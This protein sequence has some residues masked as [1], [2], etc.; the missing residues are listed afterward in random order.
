MHKLKQHFLNLSIGGK[1]LALLSIIA[2]VSTIGI[3]IIQWQVAS[4]RGA[5]D[6]QRALLQRL[7]SV[8]LAVS[9]F[10]NAKYWYADLANSLS[11]QAED[12]AAS[13]LKTFRTTIEAIEGLADTDRQTLLNNAAKIGEL[14]LAALDEYVIEERAA[15]NALMDEARTLVAENDVILTALL[16]D[17]RNRASAAADA[18]SVASGRAQLIG[19][20]TLFGVLGCAGWMLY[21]T[22]V[23]VV[24]PIKRITKAMLAVAEGSRDTEVPFAEHPAE[25]GEMARAV[26][27]FKENARNIERLNAEQEAAR[28]A[29][30]AER[31]Q[32]QRD[33]L[34]AEEAQKQVLREQAQKQK[35]LA[36]SVISLLKGRVFSSLDQVVE[37][38]NQL[39]SASKSL[40]SSMSVSSMTMS[41]VSSASETASTHAQSVATA[42]SQLVSAIQEIAGQ[43]NST[44]RVA[45]DTVAKQ[46]QVRETAERMLLLASEITKVVEMIDEIADMTNLLALNATIEAARAGEAGKGFAVVAAE[47]RSLAGQTQKATENIGRQV[48]EIHEASRATVDAVNEIGGNIFQIDEAATAMSAAI[49]EQQASTD[50]IS[51]AIN[52]AAQSTS[53]I[54]TMVADVTTEISHTSESSRSVSNAAEL[55][56]TTASELR[57]EVDEFLMTLAQQPTTQQAKA[58]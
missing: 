8:N 56:L 48:N 24:A 6:D 46:G 55:L 15:G 1:S 23:A 43:I 52:E 45:G 33:R 10:D 44:S 36:E 2:L 19:F 40:D 27:V 12:N 20:I 13:N 34:A 14:S 17:T 41:D 29:Q 50:E 53:S 11:E 18:V 51:R 37:A 47:V 54:S 5:I 9:A 58:S 35:A 3:M 16:A 21:T 25:L 38:S 28:E 49:E 4:S 57:A 22:T 42:S 39:Q 7:D 30:E 31:A 32:V 26:E